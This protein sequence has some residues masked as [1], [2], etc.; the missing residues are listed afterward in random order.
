MRLQ[1]LCRAVALLLLPS[2]IFAQGNG[3]TS[4]AAEQQAPASADPIQQDSLD[5]EWLQTFQDPSLMPGF[6]GQSRAGYTTRF[7]T[8]FNPAFGVVFDVLSEFSDV[9]E[10]AD[11]Y[12]DV[13]VRTIE[14]DVAS[15]IDPLGWAYAVVVFADV[16][17]E[18]EVELE[19]AAIWFDQLPENFSVRAGRYLADFGKWNTLHTHDKP[20]VNEDEVRRQF[21]GGPLFT[22]GVEVHHWFGVGDVPVRWS[23]GLASD[24]EGEDHDPGAGEHHEEEV[25]FVGRRGTDNW[26]A[27]AR[28]TAQHD[29]SDNGYFQWGLSGFHTPGA[30]ELEEDPASGDTIRE[31]RGKTTFAV[32]ATLRIVDARNRTGDTVSLEIWRDDTEFTNAADQV[33]SPGHNGIWGFYE[34]AFSPQWAAGAVGSWAQRA[35][36]ESGSAFLEGGESIA[37]RGAFVTWNLS[38]FN[39]LR[40][41]VLNTNP[42]IGQDSFWTFA[43]QWSALLGSHSH[44]LDW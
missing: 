5:P 16:V 29:V 24:A 10:G 39:R 9:A 30:I 40:F 18:T 35:D 33:V 17:E 25:E 38:E 11:R 3:A 43:I 44:A 27:T 4:E 6:L 19:E 28:V 31:E 34:H 12:N 26:A 14:L 23:L 2:P 15:R 32:D 22:T 42:G 20:Y 7:D 13:R 36:S 21:F 8:A 41:Q 37:S 1:P